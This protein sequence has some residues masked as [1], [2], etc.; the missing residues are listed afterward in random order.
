MPLINIIT[1]KETFAP[2]NLEMLMLFS[3][4]GFPNGTTKVMVF[5]IVII[6]NTIIILQLKSKLLL[7]FEIIA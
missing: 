7:K 4:D 6:I 2:C 5:T 1:L 3:V